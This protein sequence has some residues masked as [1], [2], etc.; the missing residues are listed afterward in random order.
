LVTVA[1][2]VGE[3]VN[4]VWQQAGRAKPLTIDDEAAE[5]PPLTM[6]LWGYC[7]MPAP[8]GPRLI[9]NAGQ[10]FHAVTGPHRSIGD[11]HEVLA[12]QHTQSGTS[13]RSGQGLELD[14]D[15][16]TSLGIG[17]GIGRRGSNLVGSGA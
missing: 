6:W 10:I 9:E 17:L 11:E 8:T 7:E 2:A 14:N 15:L 5:G 1:E 12:F 13:C 4:R 3:I 16:G